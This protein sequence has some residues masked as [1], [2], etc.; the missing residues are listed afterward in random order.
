MLIIYRNQN[1]NLVLHQ[2]IQ[3]EVVVVEVEEEE[4]EEVKVASLL[5]AAIQVMLDVGERDVKNVK[6]VFEQIVV[7]VISA[8]IWKSLEA[9]GEWNNLV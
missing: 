4:E 8:K 7:N 9:Q 2:L 6:H 1:L 5:K 3:E